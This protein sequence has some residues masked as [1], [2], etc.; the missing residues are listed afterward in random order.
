M[1]KREVH[2]LGSNLGCKL[3]GVQLVLKV[4]VV[5]KVQ[6]VG[7]VLVE[8]MVEDRLQKLELDNG[9]VESMLG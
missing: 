2:Y 9:G 7:M 1:R 8:R 4:L 5:L 6:A 3:V